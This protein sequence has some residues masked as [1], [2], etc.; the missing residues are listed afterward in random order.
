MG[1]TRQEKIVRLTGYATNTIVN[2]CNVIGC[3][4]C[5]FSNPCEVEKVMNELTKLKE[6][7]DG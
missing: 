7:T 5:P 2:V 1:E 3:K 6:D 4:D